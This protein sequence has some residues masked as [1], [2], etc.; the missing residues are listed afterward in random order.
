MG[1]RRGR[2][3]RTNVE[4]IKRRLYIPKKTKM[5]PQGR[6]KT[7]TYIVIVINSLTSSALD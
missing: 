6:P 1:G 2:Y 4:G 7:Y 3:T 5:A